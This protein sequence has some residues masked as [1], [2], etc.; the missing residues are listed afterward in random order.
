MFPEGPDRKEFG[1]LLTV[2]QVGLEMVVPI[3][4]GIYLDGRYGWSPW[5]V[6]VGAV[7]GLVSG[8][9]HLVWLSNRES[10]TPKN[11]SSRPNEETR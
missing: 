7:L 3:V 4:V 9:T 8:L 5:G 1:R 2:G 10:A 6:T 11:Q